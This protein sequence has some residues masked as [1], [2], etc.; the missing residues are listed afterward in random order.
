MAVTVLVIVAVTNNAG[1]NDFRSVVSGSATTLVAPTSTSGPRAAP[2]STGEAIEIKT[3]GPSA[4][5]LA[6]AGGKDAGPNVV[7]GSPTTQAATT[8]PAKIQPAATQPT[9]PSPSE[10]IKVKTPGEW[11]LPAAPYH[12][13]LVDLFD[14]ISAAASRLDLAT[15]QQKSGELADVAQNLRA[16]LE[17]SGPPP[18][19]IADEGPAVIAAASELERNG[20]A[21]ASC[22][23]PSDCTVA[24]GDLQS[25][26]LSYLDA[27]EALAN[28]IQAGG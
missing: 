5:P 28:R 14:T 12:S 10:T 9:P 15:V 18:P 3:P 19:P 6:P 17:S 21:V 1:K 4:P 20:R 16:A 2:T 11:A 7:S 13:E 8:Q 27:V 22:L 23:G 24:V 25:A 26:G